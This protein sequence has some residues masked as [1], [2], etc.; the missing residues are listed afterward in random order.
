MKKNNPTLFC[1]Q[2]KKISNKFEILNINLDNLNEYTSSIYD[3]VEKNLTKDELNILLK[4]NFFRQGEIGKYLG[5]NK[6]L[7]LIDK[8]NKEENIEVTPL[9]KKSVEC[10]YHDK[11]DIRNSLKIVSKIAMN[12]KRILV[13]KNE[14]LIRSKNKIDDILREMQKSLDTN[15]GYFYRQR[16]EI[17]P[18]LENVFSNKIRIINSTNEEAFVY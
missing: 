5:L 13:K 14:G 16:M 10:D 4:D 18:S 2:R 8:L 7:K 9:V 17:K 12:Q 1:F 11:E 15:T 6:S 3:L